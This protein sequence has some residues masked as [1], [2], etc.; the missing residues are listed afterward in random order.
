MYLPSG[1]FQKISD[2]MDMRALK[3]EAQCESIITDRVQEAEADINSRCRDMISV[4]LNL[5]EYQW[6]SMNSK[7]F[8]WAL[9]SFQER[10]LLMYNQRETTA[11][12]CSPVFTLAMCPRMCVEI[13]IENVS[14]GEHHNEWLAGGGGAGTTTAGSF[15][16]TTGGGPRETSNGEGEDRVKSIIPVP[17]AG[18]MNVRL[19]LQTPLD[20]LK[21]RIT[22]GPPD[23]EIVRVVT[24]ADLMKVEMHADDQHRPDAKG[25]RRNDSSEHAAQAKSRAS[26]DA[27]SKALMFTS[28]GGAS[29]R[30][31]G[32]SAV[33]SSMKGR[34]G[35]MLEFS[36]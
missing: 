13:Q 19:F 8:S 21:L 23:M 20:I 25:A 17:V 16:T 14:R 2:D 30:F 24:H 3:N 12:L 32:A 35:R 1:L 15:G 26:I 7:V 28:T 11:V 18:N 9:D 33:G 36:R 31:A 27:G 22:A 34:K 10:M 4:R 5:L 6:R 29:N